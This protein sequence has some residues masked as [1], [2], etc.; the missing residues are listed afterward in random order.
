MYNK[1]SNGMIEV[2]TGPMFSG[3]SEELLRRIR[4]LEYAKYKILVIKPAFDTRFSSSKIV[5][6]AGTEHHTI[7]LKDINE[8]YSLID[9]KINAIAIDEANF[10]SN[11]IVNIVDDLANKGYLIIVS[12][13]D[14]DYLRQPF[15]NI[16]QILSLAER[17]TKLNAICVV[18]H[19][20]ASC[21]YRKTQDN[22]VLLLDNTSNYEARCRKCHIKGMKERI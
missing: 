13:L 10:F 8:I 4:I 12:G 15:E 3:K 5:S 21:S 22:S 14:Q 1:F 17:V 19:N 2:I 20:L 18:C 9:D 11:D 16:A 6:R 7:V